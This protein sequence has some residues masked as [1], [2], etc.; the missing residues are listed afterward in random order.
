[1]TAPDGLGAFAA[2]L[3]AAS[4]LFGFAHGTQWGPPA[5]FSLYLLATTI[6]VCVMLRDDS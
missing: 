4:I 1:M 6:M 3:I 2:S 5:A